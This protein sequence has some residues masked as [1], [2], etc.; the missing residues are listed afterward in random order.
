MATYYEVTTT[1]YERW[2]KRQNAKFNE[3]WEG[4]R[5][6]KGNTTPDRPDPK[7]R[8]INRV[9]KEH[10]GFKN[11]LQ[12]IKWARENDKTYRQFDRLVKQGHTIFQAGDKLRIGGN[13]KS[14][15][16]GAYKRYMGYKGG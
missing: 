16:K 11:R 9:M 8:I 14:I 12:A 10:P 15:S 7:R 6:S 2:K 13:G 4:Q 3:Y 5:G 1:T